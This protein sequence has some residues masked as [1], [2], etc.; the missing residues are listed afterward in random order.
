MRFS[1]NL[2]NGYF[3]I[4]CLNEKHLLWDSFVVSSQD[5]SNEY[6]QQKITYIFI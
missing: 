1:S 6:P 4:L 2:K 5:D 3:I